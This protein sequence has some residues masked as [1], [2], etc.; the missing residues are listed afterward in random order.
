M[1]PQKPHLRFVIILQAYTGKPLSLRIE[2][3]KITARRSVGP[4]LRNLKHDD[5]VDGLMLKDRSLF[6]YLKRC[7][8][9]GP[10]FIIESHCLA[11]SSVHHSIKLQDRIFIENR[12]FGTIKPISAQLLEKDWPA[13]PRLSTLPTG[14]MITAELYLSINQSMIAKVA[15][16]YE[17]VSSPVFLPID[18]LPLISA[19]GKLIARDIERESSY[20]K[21]LG[22]F[23]TKDE[24]RFE[25]PANQIDFLINLDREKWKIYTT[26]GKQVYSLNYSAGSG[27]KWFDGNKYE[28]INSEDKIEY[29]LTAYLSSRKY[30]ELQDSI[31]LIPSHINTKITDELTD[32]LYQDN[33]IQ[34]FLK[35][36]IPANTSSL[37]DEHDLD[38]KLKIASF[39]GKLR[40]YQFEG[41]A[42]LLDHRKKGM[43]CLLTDEMGLGKTV[44][45]IAYLALIDKPLGPHLIIAPA[46]VIPN[47]LNELKH[48]APKISVRVQI[49]NNQ[50][51]KAGE[52]IL[53]SYNS[54]LKSKEWLKKITF[55]VIVLDEAQMVKNEKTKTSRALRSFKA[56]HKIILTGTPVENSVNEIWTHATFLF[57]EVKGMHN[58]LIRKFPDFNKNIKAAELSSSLLKPMILRRTKEEVLQELPTLIDKEYFCILSDQERDLYESIRNSFRSAIKR[59]LSAR[60]SSIA[61]E[62]LLRLRQCCSSPS[63]LPHSLNPHLIRRSTKME[64]ALDLIDD[65]LSVKRKVLFFTQFRGILDAM[66][67]ELLKRSIGTVRLDGSTLDR[68][69]PV[70][71]FQENPDISV[72]LISLRAGGV[73]L[74]L[75]AAERVII[76]D[77]WWN[78]AVEDQ[79]LSRAHRIGQNKAVLIQR[80]ICADTV[81]EKMMELKK[82]KRTIAETIGKN[83]ELSLEEL[84]SLFE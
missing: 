75:T 42:W 35:A 45:T 76:Y 79:A 37:T 46:S 80:L 56:N 64:M 66:E 70:R 51:I 8:P 28:D 63:L 39:D 11:V 12:L 3:E 10:P 47:W 7:S 2:L 54:A 52:I 16:R 4:F 22:T 53:F 49:K 21:E 19:D 24:D 9:N 41:V 31:L 34:K 20:L 17:G 78:P 5:I 84:K 73:G 69:S 26:R 30:V 27:I 13:K 59:G 48:Y 44:Q 43:G 60:I 15:F 33:N 77:P 57:P 61:L 18:N 68:L 50:A 14:N 65:A 23:L 72:F 74:N 32:V 82:T 36:A 58:S 25:I 6:Y 40:H 55:D 62:G 67:R 29:L 1:K 71:E 83:A 38:N 81:E